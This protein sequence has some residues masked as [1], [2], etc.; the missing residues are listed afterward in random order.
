M[1]E[2]DPCLLEM[3]CNSFKVGSWEFSPLE[4]RRRMK[5]QEIRTGRFLESGYSA[6]VAAL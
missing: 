2:A 3:K 6:K 5:R 4:S 1:H